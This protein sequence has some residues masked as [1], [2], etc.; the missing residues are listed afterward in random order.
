MR[1]H[2]LVGYEWLNNRPYFVEQWSMF[3]GIGCD[4]MNLYEFVPVIIVRGLHQQI[5][6]GHGLPVFHLHQA[7]LANTQAIALGGFKIYGGEISF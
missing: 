3:R 4:V 7:H 6:F 5:K 1:H 2:M